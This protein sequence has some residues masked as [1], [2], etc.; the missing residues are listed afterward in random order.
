MTP[1]LEGDIPALFAALAKAQAEMGGA[2]K[3]KANPFFKSKYAGLASVLE[4]ALPALTAHGLSLMQLPGFDAQNGLPTLT[5]ILAHEGGG[6]IISTAS[7]P[8]SKLDPQGYGSAITYLRRYAAQAAL[9][10]PSVDDDGEGAHGRGGAPVSPPRAKARPK[11]PAKPKAS[12]KQKQ[13]ARVDPEIYSRHPSFAGDQ[14]R[15][16]QNLSDIGWKYDEVCFVIEQIN[17]KNPERKRPRPSGMDQ[18][19]RDGLLRWLYAL[20][21]EE[22]DE[23]KRQYDA[24][25]AKELY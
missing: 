6:R 8:A 24:A 17:E 20:P 12:Q 9:A 23:Y 15:F 21:Q 5:T 4:V 19:S 3:G 10:I 18:E 16:G 7:I 2:K 1:T 22:A 14:K 11:A 13:A 25:Q